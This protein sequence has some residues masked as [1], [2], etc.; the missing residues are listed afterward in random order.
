MSE[1]TIGQLIKIILGIFVVVAVGIGLF[2]FFKNQI[3]DFFK[4][5]PAGNTTGI[6]MT[7]IK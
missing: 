1:L 2:L 4:G 5:L 7:L 6:F 3:F